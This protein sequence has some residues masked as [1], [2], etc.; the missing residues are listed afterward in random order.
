MKFL[1]KKIDTRIALG[2]VISAAALLILIVSMQ[3]DAFPYPS[4]PTSQ[5]D[6]EQPGQRQAIQ[7]DRRKAVLQQAEIVDTLKQVYA[8]QIEF[9]KDEYGN[10]V[11]HK[12][13]EALQQDEDTQTIF[14][15]VLPYKPQRMYRS[16]YEGMN[17]EFSLSTLASQLNIS[18]KGDARISQMMV[19][20]GIL[21]WVQ[22]QS[23]WIGNRSYVIYD[24]FFKP[25][26][27]W[28]RYYA[29]FDED[30]DQ[31]VIIGIG[32]SNCEVES[33]QKQ[34]WVNRT[35]VSYVSNVVYAKD[36]ERRIAEL[37]H[38]IN[39]ANNQH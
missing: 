5:L 8:N 7:L 25:A 38:A 35:K 2:I 19:S 16:N 33:Q 22:T 10:M 15:L 13:W 11:F 1:L 4:S 6:T 3:S 26:A 24:T 30:N 21:E 23:K 32:C 12:G 18:M 39:S 27:S 29:T 34:T 17:S 36:F 9:S 37:E 20:P 31:L 14:V 28:T